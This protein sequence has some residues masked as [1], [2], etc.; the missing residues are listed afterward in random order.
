M[1]GLYPPWRRRE[2]AATLGFMENATI[3]CIYSTGNIYLCADIDHHILY[4]MKKFIFLFVLPF[5]AITFYS[6]D[7][8]DQ[9]MDTRLIKGQWQLV[10]QE[11]PERDCIYNFTT[12]SENTWSWGILT[13]YYMDVS[14]VPVHDKVYEWHISDPNN[15]DIVYLDITLQGELDADGAW[16]NTEQYIV[17]ELTPSE[18]IL[19]KNDAGNSKTRLRFVRR[20]DLP[21][22]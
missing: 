2:A 10:S 7:D 12:Q 15:Y 8:E 18:M 3:Y 20:N 5:I 16:E 14:G 13:T 11:S 21:V 1:I 17:E 4:H 19:R 22:L 6:C 9:V